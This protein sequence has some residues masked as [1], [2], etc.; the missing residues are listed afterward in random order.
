LDIRAFLN[1]G[2]FAA[3]VCATRPNRHSLAEGS[4]ASALFFIDRRRK[5]RQRIMAAKKKAEKEKP[6]E[7]MT[8]KEMREIAMTISG[9]TGVHGMNKEE[10]LAAI[11]KERGIVDEKPGKKS[12]DVRQLKQKIKALKV[13]RQA[14]LEASDKKMA[15]IYRRRISRLKKKTHRAS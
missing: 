14:A 2:R 5:E 3:A 12:G 8:A 6:L 10:L 7:K 15:T 1:M 9:I 11:K 4:A 13:Q